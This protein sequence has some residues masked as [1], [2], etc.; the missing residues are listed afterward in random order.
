MTQ[1]LAR[2]KFE[3]NRRASIECRCIHCLFFIGILWNLFHF[4]TQC[5][6]KAV[7]NVILKSWMTC[8]LVTSW[9][10]WLCATIS[11]QWN[12]YP[13]PWCKFFWI[14]SPFIELGKEFTV[15]YGTE[16]PPPK[17]CIGPYPEPV[18]S[19][20]LLNKS[21]HFNVQKFSSEYSKALQPVSS[22]TTAFFSKTTLTLRSFRMSEIERGP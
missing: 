5:S 21:F 3:P 9:A 12:W 1:S 14:V 15:L 19:Y 7:Q 18:Q 4:S 22:L 16:G 13:S 10:T 20:P 8:V 17:S 6:C 11:Q 2:R